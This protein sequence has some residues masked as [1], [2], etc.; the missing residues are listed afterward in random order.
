VARR[1]RA[2][3]RGASKRPGDEHARRAARTLVRF[4]MLRVE[5]D[6]FTPQNAYADVVIDGVPLRDQVWRDREL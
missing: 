5:R 2:D 6:V 3:R 1:R 4:R